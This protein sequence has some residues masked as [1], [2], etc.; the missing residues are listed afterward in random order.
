MPKLFAAFLLALLA[1]LAPGFAW[2]QAPT[3]YR[4]TFADAAHHVIQVEVTFHDVPAGPLQVRMSRSSPGRYAV[5]EFAKNVFDEKITD[6]KGKPLTAARP[7][8]H[9]WDI[10]GHDG[11]VKI[12]YRLFGNRVD[13]TYLGVDTSHA[14]MNMPA[15]VMWA[16][17]FDN[18][19]ARLTFVPPSNFAGGKDWKV[20]TQ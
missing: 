16:R 13:G 20:A 17:G 18:R 15:T 10:S 7:N 4:I 19:A 9:Q 3:E 1:S 5:H 14:H 12:T 6:G 8:P 11:T 2:A